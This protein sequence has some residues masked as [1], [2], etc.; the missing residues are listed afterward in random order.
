MPTHI[1]DIPFGWCYFTQWHE[2]LH[3]VAK[4]MWN[5]AG[6]QKMFK[7]TNVEVTLIDG[8]KASAIRIDAN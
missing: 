2:A 4:Y 6:M 3:N 5:F 7:I 1:H 8:I